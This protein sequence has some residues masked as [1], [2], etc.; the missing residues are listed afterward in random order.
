MAYYD[1]FLLPVLKKNLP[2][3]RRLARKAGKIFR[4]HGALQYCECVADDLKVPVGLPFPR[5]V[6]PRAGET[7]VFACISY[8]SRRDRDRVNKCVRE[9]KRMAGMMDM[10]KLPFDCARMAWGGFKAIVDL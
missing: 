2:V 1:A 8:K 10:S 7:I 3:Y 5:L 4:D 9:D 6:K